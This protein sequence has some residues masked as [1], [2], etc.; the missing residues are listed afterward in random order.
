MR[1]LDRYESKGILG[2]GS[3]GVVHVA[4]DL[5]DPTRMV[6]VKVMR[7]EIADTPRSR[8][9][10]EREMN[11]SVRLR[12]PYIVHVHEVGVGEHG[13]CIVME[14]VQGCSLEFC[15]KQE[16]RLNLE[17]TM[18]LL[19]YLGHAL[20]AAHAAGV[21]H[22]DLKPANLMLMQVGQADES[23]KVM[24]FGLAHLANKPYLSTE[25]LAGL[26]VIRA[27]G[28][29]AYLAPE[30]LRGDEVDP[31]SDLY[32]LGVVLFETLTGR[33]PFV[34][35]QLDALL[36]AHLERT[37]PTFASLG[38]EDIP[39][40]VEA[41]V[42]RCLAKFPAERPNT[43]RELVHEFSLAIDADIWY[44]TMPATS[45]D[46]PDVAPVAQSAPVS[47]DPNIIIT[48]C[49]AWMPDRIAVVKISGFLHDMG[50]QVVSSEPGL[51]RA[52]FVAKPQ[53]SGVLAK[54]WSSPKKNSLI[55]ADI[56]L[57]KPHPSQ[58]R[59][60][61]TATLRVMGG[62][63]REKESLQSRCQDIAKALRLYLI[64]AN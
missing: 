43:A 19:G 62:S 38:I 59:L 30:Q 44:S 16:Y 35:R 64:A 14:L 54:L 56:Q 4:Q 10:F 49:E 28:T 21:I 20:Q 61:V 40:R 37:P 48:Q 46:V 47:S 32:S 7:A 1:F 23:L 45:D 31:R 24:D 33:L 18:V 8:Q 5:N 6:V 26:D 25:R 12:H 11:N 13:P 60:I 53:T 3:M 42:Q 39:P 9:L 50:G 22:R 63:A 15:L 58:S 52:H 55:E 36:A 27:Q 34:E 2:K 29:P 17:R 41:V 51:I 57:D